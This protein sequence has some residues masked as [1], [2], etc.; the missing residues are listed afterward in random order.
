MFKAAME[1]GLS[2]AGVNLASVGPMLTPAVAY[3]H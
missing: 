3:L 1:A 2:V